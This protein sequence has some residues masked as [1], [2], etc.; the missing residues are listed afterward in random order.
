MFSVGD[1]YP[2]LKSFQTRLQ[3]KGWTGRKL[4]FAKVDVQS[5]F[6]TIPQRK[7]I[8]IIEKIV[9]EQEYR[10][11]KYAEIKP[12]M[13]QGVGKPMKKFVAT[14]NLTDEFRGFG[15]FAKTEVGARKK[16][17]TVFVDD[18]VHQF[19]D[20]D[21]LLDLLEEHVQ[22]NII[23]IGKKYFRQK[24]GIPQGSVLS[25][26]LCNFFYG[27]LENN[28]LSFALSED[29]VLM[30]LIDDFLYITLSRDKA[31]K[32]VKIM[33]E[34]HPEYGAFVSIDKTMVNFEMSVGGKKVN[35]LVGTSDFP[36][37]GN[38]VNTKSLDVRKDRERRAETSMVTPCLH[39]HEGFQILIRI[40][41]M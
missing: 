1:M 22:Q 28:K 26:I 35:R 31:E 30:R 15:E 8:K 18:V 9:T 14:A 37:C 6:D 7:L 10:I 12:P 2:K 3:E 13:Y 39:K 23:K 4:Y 36:Y 27:D 33:H 40:H 29:G 24:N 19:K 5:C 11:E 20:A 32:F 17:Q 38:L 21:A 16:K 34:G 25:T 41:Q